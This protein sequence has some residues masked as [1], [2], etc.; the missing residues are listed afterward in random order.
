[1][2]PSTDTKSNK[3]QKQSPGMW[4]VMRK[5]AKIVW[6][7]TIALIT[8]FVEWV[9]VTKHTGGFRRRWLLILSGGYLWA[10]WAAQVHPFE[11]GATED[12]LRDLVIYPTQALFAPDMA[13]HV[14]VLGLIFWLSLRLAAS[15]LDDV[16]ELGDISIAEKYILQAA[17]ASSFDSIDIKDGDVSPKHRD[18]PIARIGGPGRV[19]VHLGNV[20]LF[21]KADGTPR[22]IGPG[23]EAALLDRFERL[24]EVIDLRDR[25]VEMSV[26]SRTKDGILVRA[27][28]ARM[29]FSI[30]RGGM[31]PTL[32]RP[33]PY[34][35]EDILKLIY[36]QQVFKSLRSS[37]A[38]SPGGKAP[39]S[40]TDMRDFI[41]AEM[42]RFIGESSLSEFLASTSEPEAEQSQNEK[43][44]LKQEAHRLA[45]D[46][47]GHA[48]IGSKKNATPT[49]AKGEFV[50]RD[51][52]TKR[53]YESI[54]KKA[55]QE[56]GLELHWI[57]IGTWVLPEEASKIPEQHLEAWQLSTEKSGPKK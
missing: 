19:N 30:N 8:E 55:K 39:A 18:S 57:D 5:D 13:R 32:E 7:L 12:F 15:Y 9:F 14:L 56:R 48:E 37:K 16:F 31:E 35:E 43:K 2:N 40:K 11:I 20:A 41:A 3:E 23:D 50:A 22:L 21:E 46:D 1:M 47:N 44:L 27:E 49:D 26:Q 10:W 52:L 25:V 36:E 38:D 6:D 53:L 28:G 51:E 34:K 42:K 24:R 45:S 54:N 17:F 4:E 33:Y 29:K